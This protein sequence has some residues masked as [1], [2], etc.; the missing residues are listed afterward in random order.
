MEII[1]TYIKDTLDRNLMRRDHLEALD[2]D[3]VI[4]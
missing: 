1:C 2:V 4:I 3:G